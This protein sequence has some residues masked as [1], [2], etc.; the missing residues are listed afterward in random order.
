MFMDR[1]T[2]SGPGKNRLLQLLREADAAGLRPD[3]ERVSLK[4]G[5]VCIEQNRRI[6]YVYFLESGLGSTVF[7]DENNGIVEIGMQG[8]EGLIG[9]PVLLG[10]D[11]SPHRVFMQVEGSAQRIRADILVRAME[12]SR[13]LRSLLLRYA[14]VF[15]LQAAHTAH[16]NARFAI[17][18]RLARWLLMAAD[19][20]GLQLTLTHEYLSYM[21]GTRRSG[22]TEALH[23]LE[24][25]QLIWS[26]RGCIIIRDLDSLRTLAG[27]SYGVP[28]AEYRRLIGELS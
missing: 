28:E 16:A 7:P 20:L 2:P 6:E 26:K 15:L 17:P 19:R 10:A 5:E 27:T 9:V 24:G 12:E 21:L 18:E 14:Q 22:V 8:F 23:I 1:A 13:P 25:K 3:L 4:K 11:Q